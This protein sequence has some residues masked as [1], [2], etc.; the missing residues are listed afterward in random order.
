MCPRLHFRLKKNIKGLQKG[1]KNTTY[2]FNDTF[3]I[4]S[5]HFGG[6]ISIWFDRAASELNFSY[7]HVF[8]TL[9][10]TLLIAITKKSD[11]VSTFIHRWIHVDTPGPGGTRFSK[12]L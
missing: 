5:H 3:S 1:E 4:E 6:I 11:F 7:I 9:D 8:I 2:T 12:S 10:I